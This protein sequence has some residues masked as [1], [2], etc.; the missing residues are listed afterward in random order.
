M[1]IPIRCMTCGKPVAQ[2]YLDYLEYLRNEKETEP[3]SNGVVDV[4][5]Q[6]F[7][8]KKLGLRRYCCKKEIISSVNLM[9]K[10]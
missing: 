6:D 10:I 3:D 8:E 5:R 4:S 7:L 1:I 2:K 9:D